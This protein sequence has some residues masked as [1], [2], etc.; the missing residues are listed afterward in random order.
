MYKSIMVHVDLDDPATPDRITAAAAL[1]N[2]H[3][4]TLLG[5]AASLPTA[6]IEV[7]ASGGAAIAAGVITG[8]P[9]EMDARFATAERLFQRWAGSG[10]QTEWRTAVDFP[11]HAI[12]GMAARVDLVVVGAA[13][14]S[15]PANSYLD[16]ADV[17][18]RAGRPVLAVPHAGSRF[19][20]ETAVVAWRN[21]RESR[22]ALADALPLLALAGEVHLVHVRE[23]TD[24]AEERT[25]L[26]DAVKFLEGHCI[27]ST[28][29]TLEMGSLS[30]AQR[31][32]EFAARV[33]AG[34]V[35]CGAY[36]H[37]RL[38]EWAFGGVTRD[39]MRH[40]PVPCLLSH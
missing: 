26:A 6:T 5:V 1:A 21:K 3:R 25:S 11:T 34:M 36:G 9:H 8:D 2:Q 18:M 30:P 27:G 17:V 32:V 13:R 12:I 4:A 10:I 15:T 24:D 29:H 39:L 35:V 20:A 7:L 31:I 22:R 37:T 38:R 19:E 28:A 16:Y 23:T 14:R 40:C 33:E